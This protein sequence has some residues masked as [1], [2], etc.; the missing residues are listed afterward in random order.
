VHHLAAPGDA[1]FARLTRHARSYRMQVVR[2]SFVGFDEEVNQELM[3]Q[4]TFEWPH[5]FARLSVG[6]GEFLSHFGAN[7]IHA[8]P[9]DQVAGLQAV[10]RFLGISFEPL[11]AT[12]QSGP[13]GA[14]R[15][16]SG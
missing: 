16:P 11:G 8:V 1:T 13:A 10:C 6:S 15:S 2:G 9:G 3:R 14:A 12:A 4:S 5:A 7:H